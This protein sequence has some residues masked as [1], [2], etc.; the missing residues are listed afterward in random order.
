MTPAITVVVPCYN[1][2]RYLDRLRTSLDAQTFRDFEVVI[3]DDGSTDEL[4]RDKL[5]SLDGWAERTRVVRQSNRGLAGARNTGFREAKAEFVLP[6]DCDDELDRTFLQRTWQLMRDAIPEVGFVFTHI[7]LAGARTGVRSCHFD[8]FDQLFVNDVLYCMLI[9]KSAWEAC[10]GYDETMRDGYED[11]EFNIRLAKTGYRGLELA[12][13]LVT[14]WVNPDGMLHAVSLP[15]HAGLWRGIR[16]KHAVLYRA[17]ALWT[18][19]RTRDRKRVRIS[20]LQGAALLC[21]A[22]LLPDRW[23]SALFALTLSIRRKMT[24]KTVDQ[25]GD[26]MELAGRPRRE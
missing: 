10:G 21:L 5:A 3:V 4:T 6:L 2:G 14:Y 22:K 9:R 7:R 12:E 20:L 11:W 18:A 19:S 17:G 13:P 24:P 1:G 26:G 23:Y 15:R 25:Y 16:E 8:V